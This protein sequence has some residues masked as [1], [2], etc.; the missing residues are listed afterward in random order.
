MSTRPQANYGRFHAIG[1]AELV[2]PHD[3]RRIETR[4][5]V[6][7]V[8]EIRKN[9]SEVFGSDLFSDPAWDILLELFAAELT[10][11][12]VKLAD[13]NSIAALSTVARWLAALEQ[14]GLIICDGDPLE[15]DNFW[16]ELSRDC[17]AKMATF[18]SGERSPVQFG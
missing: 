14:R 5:L 9:R 18:L 15:A 13:L 12:K 4:D 1:A 8:L 10:K 2:S 7:S 16:I 17:A 6:A 11:R 3:K